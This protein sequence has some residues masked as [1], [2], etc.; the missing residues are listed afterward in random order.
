MDDERLLQIRLRNCLQTILD[1]NEN[2]DTNAFRLAFS[3]E[4]EFM[5]NFLNGLDSI[6]LSETDVLRIE[7]ATEVFFKELGVFFG[8]GRFLKNGCVRLRMQ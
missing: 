4:L 2:M 5:R 1:L 7:D 3:G 6:I 8:N